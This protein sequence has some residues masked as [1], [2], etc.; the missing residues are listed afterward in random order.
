MQDLSRLIANLKKLESE[1]SFLE[2]N[3][4]QLAMRKGELLLAIKEAVL[5]APEY[6]VFGV[7]RK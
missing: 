2:C 4:L 3:R 6:P 1:K 7:S 5:H